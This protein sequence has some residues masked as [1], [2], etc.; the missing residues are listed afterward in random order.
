VHRPTHPE[1][2]RI[3]LRRILYRGAEH[4]RAQR[5]PFGSEVR[6]R[7]GWRAEHSPMVEVSASGCRLHT[8]RGPRIDALV[9][10]WIPPEATG[11]RRIAL[12]GRVVRRDALAAPDPRR[13]WELAV[14]FETLSRR[15][16]SR[17]DALLARCARR[18][19]LLALPV[20]TGL[21]TAPPITVLAAA[22]PATPTLAA[23]P[24][25]PAFPA[26]P[27]VAAPSDSET[28]GVGATPAA[29]RAAIASRVD[30]ALDAEPDDAPAWERRAAPAPPDP[31]AP[32]EDR[33][34]LPR[35]RL[36]HGI[37]AL[38]DAS[39]RALLA[40]VGRDLSARGMRIDPHPELV[41]HQRLRIALY[42]ASTAAPLLL[43][44]LVARDDGEAGLGLHFVDLPPEA[45]AQLARLVSAL[46]SVQTLHPRPARVVVGELLL[47]ERPAA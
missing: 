26:T 28:E 39:A 35:A 23:A 21:E 9:R 43:D 10:I 29:T 37:V 41:L 15:M 32:F 20:A 8:R 17:L 45:A 34:R 31:G 18:P 7:T 36:E 13:R 4:R 33:R 12:R 25:T 38:D 6:W 40:L 46:P 47:R 14:E 5:L 24:E 16:Q 3:L 2:L 44:A 22:T 19:G 30:F 27:T 1:A 42:D 11:D